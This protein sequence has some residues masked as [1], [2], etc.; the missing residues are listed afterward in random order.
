M[1]IWG[2]EV[3]DRSFPSHAYTDKMAFAP[4]K[5]GSGLVAD[6][7]AVATMVLPSFKKV[8]NGHVG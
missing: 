5:T 2:L 3:G 1:G 7:E 6:T 4:L 8:Y